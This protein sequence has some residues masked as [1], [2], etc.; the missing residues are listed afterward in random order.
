MQW[1]CW[2]LN[3]RLETFLA[4]GNCRLDQ[5]RQPI[6]HIG[7]IPSPSSSLGVWY[8]RC[9]KVFWVRKR[10]ALKVWIDFITQVHEIKK[11]QQAGRRYLTLVEIFLHH[12]RY[13]SSLSY[14]TSC[15]QDFLRNSNGIRFGECREWV[16]DYLTIRE[17]SNHAAVSTYYFNPIRT[18]K[19]RRLYCRQ[20]AILRVIGEAPLTSELSG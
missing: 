20:C 18:Y 7:H 1:R 9:I 19:V 16:L 14:N 11:L 5:I 8:T 13:H 17:W 3:V 2:D 12:S 10:L 15:S 4:Y 6:L